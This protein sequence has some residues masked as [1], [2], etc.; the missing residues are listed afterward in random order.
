MGALDQAAAQGGGG[1]VTP[2][3]AAAAA[4]AGAPAVGGEAGAGAPPPAAAAP[5]PQ[6]QPA[7]APAGGAPSPAGGMTAPP[8]APPPGA[9]PRPEQ[10]A[11]NEGGGASA[12]PAGAV[13]PYLEDASPEEQKEYERA[14]RAMAKVL[15]GNDKTANSIVDQITPNDL[16]GSTAKVSM[17]FIKE[18][19]RKINMDQMVVAEV[20]RESVERIAELAEARHRVE[21]KAQD[22]EQ[23]LGATWEGVQSM[24]GNEGGGE[25]FQQTVNQM[26]PKDL[27]TLQTQNSQI[28][29]GAK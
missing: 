27:E 2:D 7:P 26:A 13:E 8:G 9:E 12:G 14:I 3:L 16:V 17:L 22:M 21:Y 10:G 24:F 19:D 11:G 4:Q 5:A 20:T 18:L 29:S 25:S 23:V 1:A 6:A 28:L 15:Y